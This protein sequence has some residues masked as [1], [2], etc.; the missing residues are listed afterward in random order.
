MMND[1]TQ[2]P[3]F[4]PS[5]R[6]PQL[7]SDQTERIKKETFFNKFK[8]STPKDEI[9]LTR[10]YRP[11]TH[12]KRNRHWQWDDVMTRLSQ[13]TKDVFN[14]GCDNTNSEINEQDMASVTKASAMETI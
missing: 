1:S 13:Q 5:H 6:L 14:E 3:Q 2:K 12:A 9:M 10:I 8:V 4:V 7:D 11:K